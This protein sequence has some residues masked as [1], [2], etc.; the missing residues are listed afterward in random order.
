MQHELGH[1]RVKELTCEWKNWFI[2]YDPWIVFLFNSLLLF[3]ADI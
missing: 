1:S 2:Q 3:I